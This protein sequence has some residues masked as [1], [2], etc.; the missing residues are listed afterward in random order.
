MKVRIFL[1]VMSALFY[2]TSIWG[3]EV[4]MS[5]EQWDSHKHSTDSLNKTILELRN[6]INTQDSINRIELHFKD[7]QI[8]DMECRF[9][10]LKALY[11]TDSARLITVQ[12]LLGIEKDS[13]ILLNQRMVEIEKKIEFADRCIGRFS[14]GRLFQSY[15]KELVN[16]AKAMFARISSKAVLQEFEQVPPLLDY[17]ESAFHEIMTIIDNAQ[18][19]EDRTNKFN[20][21]PYRE[22]Y[23]QELL[24]SQYYR[25]YYSKEWN[26][27]YLNRQ[28]DKALKR[29]KS[30]NTKDAP[31]A[32]FID[33]LEDNEY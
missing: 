4:R 19:D 18:K 9:D 3:Q 14:N 12:N 6:S 30:H 2:G 22:K 7:S 21:D 1:T 15:N 20:A 23:I 27:P 5:V 16:E 28:I 13:I 26:I 33:I 25:R 31:Y 11:R 29:L 32:N 17:Y 10:N 24:H 8:E